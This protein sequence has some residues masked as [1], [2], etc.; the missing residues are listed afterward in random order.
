[1]SNFTGDPI[2]DFTYAL[3]KYFPLR[4]AGLLSATDSSRAFR[5]R[6][7]S[8]SLNDLLPILFIMKLCSETLNS[9]SPYLE[10]FTDS[11]RSFGLTRVPLLTFGI[12][13]FGPRIRANFL[14]N[15][16]YSGV[17]MILSNSILPSEMS[18]K[19]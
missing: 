9:T 2:V 1:M 15:C 18:A 17:A 14:S 13:P 11:T 8:S 16:I 12:N 19:T 3:P 6:C 10:F 7:K 4:E 5:F